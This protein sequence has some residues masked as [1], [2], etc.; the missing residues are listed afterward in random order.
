MT[1][2][3]LSIFS[4]CK[5]GNEDSSLNL[6]ATVSQIVNDEI[7]NAYQNNRSIDFAALINKV[8]AVSGVQ[9]A[10][11]TP[12]GA[13]LNI[14]N[15]DGTSFSIL[16]VN[17]NDDRAFK[18]FQTTALAKSQSISPSGGHQISGLFDVDIPTISAS[19]IPLNNR[20]LILAPFQNKF[21][22]DIV[23][24]RKILSN[25]GFE[26]TERLNETATLDMFKGDFLAQF[27]VIYISTHGFADC[28]T[29]TT[30]ETSTALF[31]GDLVKKDTHYNNVAEAFPSG[32]YSQYYTITV[33]FL[34]ATLSK[35]FPNSWV[36]VEACESAKGLDLSDFFLKNGAK[37]F[38]GFALPI[39]N[40]L[41][42]PIAVELTA[43]LASGYEFMK[44]NDILQKY[45]G[46]Y[47]S[48]VE[49]ANG[50]RISTLNSLTSRSNSNAA[51]TLVNHINAYGYLN[52]R[53]GSVNKGTQ[54]DLSLM[55]N[56]KSINFLT[57]GNWFFSQ[58][59]APF[60]YSIRIVNNKNIAYPGAEDHV[61]VDD[62]HG[63]ITVANSSSV[64]NPY[65]KAAIIYISTTS[66]DGYK[67]FNIPI[68]FTVI[69]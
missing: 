55:I 52:P 45:Q 24:I 54:L 9:T 53:F 15:I 68:P 14:Q 39:K 18:N 59:A 63:T 2:L 4:A 13:A 60:N 46:L 69:N 3:C 22:R 32:E 30:G 67:V 57:D 7:Q 16:L 64:I 17:S 19:N 65:P 11:A 28:V 36:F 10:T 40:P 33:P 35:K 48:M 23:T 26:V 50:K 47:G 6:R 12:S 20:A 25:A 62:Y 38:N 51:F 8:K 29:S 58:N 49:I 41:A 34:K 44:A 66:T 37:A 61:F 5:K 31:T 27:G 42:D 43:L 56:K 1:I 21:Q